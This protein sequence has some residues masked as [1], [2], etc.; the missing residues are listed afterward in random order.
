MVRR[1]RRRPHD[2]I[3][4]PHQSVLVD[5]LAREQMAVTDWVG[6]G[7]GH[8]EVAAEMKLMEDEEGA[9]RERKVLAAAVSWNAKEAEM[10][11]REREGLGQNFSRWAHIFLWELW[12]WVPRTGRSFGE[13][14]I[15]SH[16]EILISECEPF[17]RQET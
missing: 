12:D 11:A 14:R 5:L 1:R 13:D 2:V 17:F 6:L 10:R 9:R 7:T 4:L 3:V 16:P 15:L 8:V